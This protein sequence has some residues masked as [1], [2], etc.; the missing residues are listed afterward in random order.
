MEYGLYMCKKCNRIWRLPPGP[1]QCECGG[2]EVEWLNWH[3]WEKDNYEKN[4]KKDENE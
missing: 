2:I 3:E 1:Q 4:R